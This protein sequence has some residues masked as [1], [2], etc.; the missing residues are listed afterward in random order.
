MLSPEIL[1]PSLTTSLASPHEAESAHALASP[2]GVRCAPRLQRLLQINMAALAALGTSLLGMGQHSPWLIALGM[3]SSL[4]SLLLVDLGGWFHLP[5]WLMNLLL[6]GALGATVFDVIRHP[7][8]L[9]VLLVANLLV[10]LQCVLQFQR[11]D[12]RLYRYLLILSVFQ[13]VSAS[14]FFHGVLFGFLLFF[15]LVL[16]LIVLILSTSYAEWISQCEHS[17]G[18]LPQVRLG[19]APLAIA[20]VGDPPAPGAP[21]GLNGSLIRRLAALVTKS[22]V[23]AL[24]VFLTV[25]RLST[26]P[27]PGFSPVPLRTVGFADNVTLGEI[28]ELLEDHSPVMTLELAT[29]SGEPVGYAGPLYLRGGAL[30]AYSEGHWTLSPFL[31]RN[32]VRSLPPLFRGP[33]QSLVVQRLV[34]ER[35]ES[36][37]VFAIWP[38][39]KWDDSG[40]IYDADRTRLLRT[41]TQLQRATIELTTSGLEYGRLADLVP[42]S[43]PV[44]VSA[45]LQLP[46]VVFQPDWWGGRFVVDRSL[47]E[48]RGWK[49]LE[50]L[51]AQWAAESPW[52]AEDHFHLA[53]HFEQQLA[54]SGEFRYSL[55]AVPR[56]PQLDP[57]VD[58]LTE[59]REGH[60]EYFAT[61]LALLLRCRGIPTRIV[62]G[63]K[64]DEFNPLGNFYQIRQRDAH[65]WV[66]AFI[67]P[68]Q[69]NEELLAEK[70]RELWKHGAWLRLDATPPSA[71]RAANRSFFN[72]L[73]TTY[74]F[75]DYIWLKYV[76]QL[77]RPTQ[78]T[79]VYQ[80][81]QRR[82]R[83]TVGTFFDRDRWLTSFA[84]VRAVIDA[85]LRSSWLLLLLAVA[86]VLVTS[87]AILAYRVQRDP[88]W[89]IWLLKR[90]PL[91][92]RI[93]PLITSVP[94]EAYAH[95]EGLFRAQG[96]RREAWECPRAF[97]E[98]AIAKINGRAMPS[99][100]GWIDSARLIV[101][102]YYQARFGKG[103]LSHERVEQLALAL[104]V[105]RQS[106]G[107]PR[108]F[109]HLRKSAAARKRP[110]GDGPAPSI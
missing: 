110:T 54:F 70:P 89:R 104:H 14:A 82:V 41:N 74:T 71:E 48:A 32:D 64:T 100:N 20:L 23:F 36:P 24:A 66:E 91:S 105:V 102:T 38:Y 107:R 3:T 16:A 78:R 25:P 31:L 42:A 84:R 40:L 87:A 95:L 28:G 57:I 13:V 85:N 61:A 73:W 58:F 43:E 76:V 92:E 11:K 51:A 52:P 67:P 47:Y 19:T 88:F 49:Y 29:L 34:L 96:F 68:H 62:I 55:R 79:E 86:G 12:V 8:G 93:S 7:G 17:R 59:H 10:Y 45:H 18:Q 69:L 4:C 46:W 60:C 33:G 26:R 30:Q 56:N 72:R 81:V 15:Y 103:A 83:E 109:Q 6:L 44:S 77:D 9:P 65:A 2:P 63:Y 75:L 37:E 50:E 53:K 22:A 27:W 108:F 101:D 39:G 94:L 98:K 1:I 99:D 90:L 21:L 106:L 97:V 80:P 5:R 35:L